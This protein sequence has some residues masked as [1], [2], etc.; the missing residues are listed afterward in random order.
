MYEFSFYG[1]GNIIKPY[2]FTDKNK[3]IESYITYMLNRV[4]SMFSYEGLPDTIPQK[5]LELYIM[6]NGHS[7]VIDHKDS[8]YVCFGGWGG[9]PN[10]YY[11]PTKYIVANPYLDLFKTYTIN[12]DCVLVHNDSMYYGLVPMF[13]R[14]ATM[15]AENDITMSMVDVNSRITAIIE[16]SDDKT[17]VSAEKFLDDI[18]AGKQGVVGSQ[19]FFEGLHTQPYGEHNYQRLTDLIEYHQYMKASWFNELGLNANYNMK[20]EAITS[21]ESQLNDDQ[22]LP[23]ID[24]MMKCRQEFIER[25]NNMYGTDITISYASSWEDNELELENAQQMEAITLSQE[26]H[27]S[28]VDDIDVDD[29]RDIDNQNESHENVS[30]DSDSDDSGGEPTTVTIEINNDG[31]DINVSVL[32]DTSDNEDD[33]QPNDD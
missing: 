9:E 12:E 16:A 23:L 20:R 1:L 26:S 30:S 29:T 24:D 18:Y 28:F 10:E 8:L 31:G 22:L 5:M 7:V 4:Q 6:I 13:R 17:R 2:D 15:L 25:I 27:S 11:I 33:V 19:A 32:E 3:A 21:N 14:Y